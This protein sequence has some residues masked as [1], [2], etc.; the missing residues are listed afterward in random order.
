MTFPDGT[1]AQETRMVTQ[2]MTKPT[3]TGTEESP[4]GGWNDGTDASSGGAAF[5]GLIDTLRLVQD[6][7]AEAAAPDDVVREATRSLQDVTAALAPYGVPGS[8]QITGHRL[9]LPGRGQALVPAFHVD[10]W[11]EEH[12]TGRFR[13]G[14]YYL[15]GN[16]AAHGGVIPLMFDEV[17]GRLAN[18]G[19]RRARTAFLHVN[20]RSVTPIGPELRLTARFSREEGRKR[21]LTATIH[22]DDVL[23]A[24]AEALFVALRPGQP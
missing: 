8:Q 16:G 22:H 4:H 20:F 1:D 14:R 19:R 9:D 2:H 7:I 10:E 24:D 12:A 3:P 17:L 15:G 18:T 5:A 13:L 21:Y 11:D 6:R 23:T